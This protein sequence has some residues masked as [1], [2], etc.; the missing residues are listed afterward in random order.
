MTPKQIGKVKIYEFNNLSIFPQINHFVSTRLGGLSKSPYDSLNLS[1]AVGDDEENVLRNRKILAQA[2]KIPFDHFVFPQQ[3]HTA[4]VVRVTRTIRDNWRDDDSLLKNVDS[5]ITNERDTALVIGAADCVPIMLYD[6]VNNAIGTA[7]AGWRGTAARVVQNAIT[8][9]H[10]E[11]DTN[12]GD[13][14]AGIGP[15]IGPESYEVDTPVI[16]AFEVAFPEKNFVKMKDEIH[17]ML[18]LWEANKYQLL[19]KGVLEENI[20]VA[21]IDTYQNTQ[22]F[23][24]DRRQRPTGRFIAGITLL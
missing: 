6:P 15:S 10:E 3:K 9:M 19:E 23:F 4:N 11:F 2:V 21:E 22:E 24:S 20:E 14:I 5:L 18:D 1:F 7:H 13:L 12:P 16:Q 17:G 8:R